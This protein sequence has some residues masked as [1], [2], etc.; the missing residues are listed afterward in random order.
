[1][2]RL[3]CDR[4][5]SF[6]RRLISRVPSTPGVTANQGALANIGE[7]PQVIW[8]ETLA[9]WPGNETR[10]QESTRSRTEDRRIMPGQTCGGCEIRTREA[11]PPTRFPS[12]HPGVHQGPAPSVTCTAG[13]PLVRRGRRWTLANETG[14]ETGKGKRI[15]PRSPGT[16]ELRMRMPVVRS[17]VVSRRPGWASPVL[18]SA[19][20]AGWRG[21]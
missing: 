6:R 15:R 10:Q 8:L 12:L 13:L 18:S 7:Y 3:S 14:T 2:L 17:W 9:A 20:G 19:T 5:G 11:L 1:M 16:S 4:H 21:G